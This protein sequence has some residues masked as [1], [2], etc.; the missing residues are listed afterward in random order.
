MTRANQ[1]LTPHVK[2]KKKSEKKEDSFLIFLA[3]YR[4]ALLIIGWFHQILLTNYGVMYCV[5]GLRVMIAPV[6]EC[7]LVR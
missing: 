6:H 7:E 1:S 2:E 4:V 3:K 5:K